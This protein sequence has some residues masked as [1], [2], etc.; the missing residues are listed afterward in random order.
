[1]KIESRYAMVLVAMGVVEGIGR[2]LD[3]DVDILRQAAP[4]VLRGSARR[5]LHGDTR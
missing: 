3:P 4:Y 5:L 2:Q 1:M